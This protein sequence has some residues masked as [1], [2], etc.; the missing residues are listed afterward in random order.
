MMSDPRYKNGTFR[1][2]TNRSQISIRAAEGNSPVANG[3]HWD[4]AEEHW[5]LGFAGMTAWLRRPT[6]EEKAA[7]GLNALQW[8]VGIENEI[9]VY[10]AWVNQFTQEVKRNLAQA[11]TRRAIAEVQCGNSWGG[12][13]E[14]EYGLQPPF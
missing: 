6:A 2:F 10:N 1:G 3:W 8:L 11:A 9:Q 14:S 13:P 5:T 12:S 7:Y 4:K